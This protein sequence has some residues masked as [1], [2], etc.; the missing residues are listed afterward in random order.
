MMSAMLTV[1]HRLPPAAR[2]AAATLR[3]WYLQRWRE[4]ASSARKAEEAVAREYWTAAQWAAWR[5]ERLGF[6]LHRAAT[7]VPFYRE[8]WLARRRRGDR[9][10]WSLL[11][12][13]P[14]LSKDALRVHP[15]AFVAE[16]C[17]PARMY[18]EKTSG[19]TGR[20]IEVWRTRD[21]TTTL[22]AI[23]NTRTRG[24]DG[25][26]ET[27]RW[28]RFGGQLVVP[29]R[30]RRPPFW[31]WNA[32]MRQ[33]YMSSYHLAPDLAPYYLDALLRYRV[34]YLAG[35]PSALHA[36]AQAALRE[37]T[38][39]DLTMAAVY[40][41][42]E[43]V[44]PDQRDAIAAA[45]RCPV[46]EAYGMTE[47]VA[48]GSECPAGRMHQ[49]PE[50]GIIERQDDGELVCTGLLNADMPLIRYRVGDRGQPAPAA[51]ATCECGRTL[52]LMGAIEGRTN[53]LLLTRDGRRVA[54][55]SSVFYDVPVRE[56]QIVQQRLDHLLVRVA[57]DAEFTRGHERVIAHRLRER[58]GDVQ[59][60]V[61]RVPEVPRI[62][63]K[64]RVM[65]CDL[66]PE[67]RAEALAGGGGG[68]AR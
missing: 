4:G 21:T 65:I 28:A 17:T 23:S 22:F 67:E 59:V 34:V 33:L 26:P 10:S 20:P 25:I 5:A 56:W 1:Y 37:G 35:Y 38:V 48:A 68:A 49:W 53:D 15:R 30:Q 62:N 29:V 27:A 66:S 9:S 39:H 63:G 52:P 58:V 57:P 12:N 44:L 45:F 32:A 11:E 64:L 16:D 47:A 51:A 3:G 54:W 13:W 61:E 36:L 50:F 41:N 2:S 31:V 42:A 40:T 46:R 8:Q 43:P 55:M 18:H 14:V 60:V 24:W 6:V 7:Q 19:S